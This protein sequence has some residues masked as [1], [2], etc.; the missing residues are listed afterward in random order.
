MR[1]L[2]DELGKLCLVILDNLAGLSIFAGFMLW[3]FTKAKSKLTTTIAIPNK[4]QDEILESIISRLD[5]IEEDNEVYHKETNKNIL[6][7]QIEDGIHRRKFSESEVLERYD[8]YKNDYN[9][10][11]YITHLVADY[12][13]SLHDEP[14]QL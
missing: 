3:L 6:R 12:L 10:N 11:G 13:E 7:I 14:H 2:V 1:N 9:G 8:R 5:K 4:Q